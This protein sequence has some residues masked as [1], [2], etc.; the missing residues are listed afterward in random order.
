[1]THDPNS[2][3]QGLRRLKPLHKTTGE[4]GRRSRYIEEELNVR[5][6]WKRVLYSWIHQ[7]QHHS[8][9]PTLWFA[10]GGSG[11]SGGSVRVRDSSGIGGIVNGGGSGGG[12]DRSGGGA[13]SFEAMGEENELLQE[14]ED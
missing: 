9:Y 14:E 12:C 2:Q 4:R 7:E 6:K 11:G 1:M 8:W 5:W 10:S 3:V 13:L